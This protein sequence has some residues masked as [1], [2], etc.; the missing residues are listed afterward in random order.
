MFSANHQYMYG[1]GEWDTV[2]NNKISLREKLSRGYD[3]F[4]IKI[5]LQLT[6]S[7]CVMIQHREIGF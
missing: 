4:H 1:T 5:F 6:P 2:V 7:A 3:Y